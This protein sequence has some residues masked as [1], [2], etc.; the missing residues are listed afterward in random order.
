MGCVCRGVLTTR[1]PEL[2]VL[3]GN[4]C[5]RRRENLPWIVWHISDRVISS[6]HGL[7]GGWRA[8]DSS[9]C[10]DLSRHKSLFTVDFW[11]LQHPGHVVLQCWVST[12][13]WWWNINDDIITA[14]QLWNVMESSCKY[15]T[16][17]E[18]MQ[19]LFSDLVSCTVSGIRYDVCEEF[20]AFHTQNCIVSF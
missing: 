15:R 6:T 7:I 1:H 9:Q 10:A 20:R 19:V 17:A 18:T 12:C 4:L 8:T 5:A 14:L 16:V 3:G 13:L 2:A 11:L